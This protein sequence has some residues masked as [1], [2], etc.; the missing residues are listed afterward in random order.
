MTYE[1][2][3]CVILLGSSLGQEL[4]LGQTVMLGKALVTVTARCQC[5]LELEHP[6]ELATGVCLPC[7]L[8]SVP[9]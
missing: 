6:S 7:Q 5:G 3:K 1:D 2:L 8:G 4:P 9:M